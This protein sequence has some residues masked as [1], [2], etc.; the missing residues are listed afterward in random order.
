MLLSL[1][2]V[3]MLTATPQDLPRFTMTAQP[4]DALK[5][6]LFRLAPGDPDAQV[7]DLLGGGEAGAFTLKKSGALKMTYRRATGPGAGLV[8]YAGANSEYRPDAACL[9]TRTVDGD[10]DNSRRAT[11]WCL[12]FILKTAPTLNIPPAPL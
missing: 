10:L 7:R 3:G 1:V 8:I 6:E 11:D 5:A 9:L 12:S 2:I 4:G